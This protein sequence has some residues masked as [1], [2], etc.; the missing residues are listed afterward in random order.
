MMVM[1]LLREDIS[2]LVAVAKLGDPT[3]W[4]SRQKPVVSSMGRVCTFLSVG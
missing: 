2:C 3:G 1:L 4:P